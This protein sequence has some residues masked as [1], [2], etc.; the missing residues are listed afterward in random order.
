ML[1]ERMSAMTLRLLIGLSVL[2]AGM[3]VLNAQTNPTPF[4]LSTGNY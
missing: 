2:L 1:R 4:D 3:P